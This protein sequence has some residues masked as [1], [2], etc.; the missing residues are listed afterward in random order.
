[1]GWKCISI[2]WQDW[3]IS[4]CLVLSIDKVLVVLLSAGVW[5]DGRGNHQQKLYVKEQKSYKQGEIINTSVANI[6]FLDCMLVQATLRG[7]STLIRLVACD[8]VYI[9]V[10]SCP[11]LDTGL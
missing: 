3:L 7:V 10:S 6:V 8:W 5:E 11:L 4:T 2:Y 1:M 9:A